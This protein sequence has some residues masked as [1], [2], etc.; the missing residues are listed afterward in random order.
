[1]SKFIFKNIIDYVDN[2]VYLVSRY[3]NIKN[4]VIYLSE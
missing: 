1:M 2:N 4:P 3:N